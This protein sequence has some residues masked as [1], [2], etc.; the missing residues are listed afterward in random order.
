LYTRCTYCGSIYQV[1]AAILRQA[2]G[3]VRCGVCE[4]SFDALKLLNESLPDEPPT[5][6]TPTRPAA[7][8]PDLFAAGAPSPTSPVDEHTLTTHDDGTQLQES[9]AEDDKPLTDL[10]DELEVL[11]SRL[12]QGIDPAD[13]PD[14]GYPDDEDPAD[15]DHDGDHD[16]EPEQGLE[17]ALEGYDDGED[18]DEDYDEDRDDGDEERGEEEL[19][20]DLG[21]EPDVSMEST[22]DIDDHLVSAEPIGEDWYA[23]DP[24]E[25]PEG[26]RQ[27]ML[28]GNED[29]DDV[30]L[31]DEE[32]DEPEDEA[33]EP[34]FLRP[35]EALSGFGMPSRPR[36]AM[37]ASIIAVAT[38]LAAV[39]W[40]HI[41]RQEL[42]QH[43]TFGPR[44]TEVYRL[45]GVD[46][47]PDWDPEFL[48]VERT[49][50]VSHPSITGALFLSGVLSNEAPY[51]LP[52]PT[53][54]L[55]MDN[56]WGDVLAARAFEPADYLRSPRDPDA[57]F[58]PGERVALGVEILDP[59]PEA[60]GFRVQ[61]CLP[62]EGGDRCR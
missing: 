62:A 29:L 11:V 4:Q 28:L 34:P 6:T 27:G 54:R 42:V 52:L 56:R 47:H 25:D 55:R 30:D 8:T 33:A 13:D 32:G 40:V 18:E 14:D 43:P 3:Q 7:R 39:Q 10:A 9:E 57:L 58:N 22:D 37:W 26:P 38:I 35:E 36:I 50:M 12:E 41:E 5:L 31:S 24:D 53:L 44:L 21:L 16:V 59:D 51:P 60:V 61:V 49:E 20:A 1:D 45:F 48:I 19:H 46:L 15:D 2:A 17:A 23:D